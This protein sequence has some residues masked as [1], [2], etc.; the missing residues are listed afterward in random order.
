VIG[1]WHSTHL[2]SSECLA[3]SPSP[4]T[5]GGGSL[6][7]P[8]CSGF[9]KAMLIRMVPASKNAKPGAA[10]E[11]VASPDTPALFTFAPKAKAPVRPN[12]VIITP[13]SMHA[14]PIIIP[15]PIW[16]AAA[17][18]SLSSTCGV[19]W[20]DITTYSIT[21]VAVVIM[22]KISGSNHANTNAIAVN[23]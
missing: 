18:N 17:N 21:P 5:A 16:I 1:P 20:L 13:N 3:S 10:L 6:G 4:A 2:W 8:W 11:S 15:K 9:N 23:A 7:G 19:R 12:H 22:A 14:N